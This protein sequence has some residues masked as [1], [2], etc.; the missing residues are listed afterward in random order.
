M[1]VFLKNI[2]INSRTLRRR[3]RKYQVQRAFCFACSFG[4]AQYS[5]NLQIQCTQHNRHY[6]GMGP[7]LTTFE[8]RSMQNNLADNRCHH[9]NNEDIYEL[10]CLYSEN[11]RLKQHITNDFTIKIQKIEKNKP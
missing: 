6:K 5:Y 11:K 2:K 7:C 8:C 4:N 3:I 10:E 1:Q 9:K